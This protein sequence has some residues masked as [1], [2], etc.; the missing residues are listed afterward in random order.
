MNM[1]TRSIHVL[2]DCSLLLNVII[3]MP[4]QLGVSARLAVLSSVSNSPITETGNRKGRQLRSRGASVPSS[5]IGA[6]HL[7][8]CTEQN[9]QQSY[10]NQGFNIRTRAV[11]SNQI[12]CCN[13]A[14][15]KISL[16][17]LDAYM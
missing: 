14:V 17:L 11:Q 10:T 8:E 16:F 4:K 13:H 15:T 2:V 7:T 5:F 6:N 3:C 12:I 9:T 1:Y